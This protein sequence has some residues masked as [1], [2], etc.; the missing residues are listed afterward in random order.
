MLFFFSFFP[1][2]LAQDFPDV[3]PD[4]WF[5]PYVED[6]KKEGLLQG[7]PDGRFGSWD[8]V[9]RAELAKIISLLKEKLETLPKAVLEATPLLKQ[10]AEEVSWLQD[11]LF[12][13]ILTMITVIGWIT[14]LML[15]RKKMSRGSEQKSLIS[16]APE[17]L[18][19]NHP[20][21]L[22]DLEIKNPH[23]EVHDE[24][25]TSSTNWWL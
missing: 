12:E 20:R 2:V 11:H 9:N 13:L 24:N 7:Y 25:K 10:P 8:P 22:K 16:I 5:F 15:A 14:V 23:E 19:E 4:D 1:S 17:M 18:G 3:K 6:L 21:S